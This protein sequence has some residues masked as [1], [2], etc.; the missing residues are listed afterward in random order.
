MCVILVN[1]FWW[2]TCVGSNSNVNYVTTGTYL[3]HY[4]S[5]LRPLS[6]FMLEWMPLTWI[7]GR[8]RR[9]GE[10][11]SM[12]VSVFFQCQSTWHFS[13][14]TL[15]HSI[16][17]KVTL[18]HFSEPYFVT[19]PV[20]R[21]QLV[22]LVSSFHSFCWDGPRLFSL[23]RSFQILWVGIL[24][25][26]QSHSSTRLLLNQWLFPGRK[27]SEWCTQNSLIMW[28]SWFGGPGSWEARFRLH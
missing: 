13:Q 7:N 27:S 25:K 3:R 10:Q 23:F 24:K 11:Q 22:F 20:S 9:Q 6:F 1:L 8:Q 14:V 15:K 2:K 26:H 5:S 18:K 28:R 4:H 17:K 21:P 12:H 19:L 16:K